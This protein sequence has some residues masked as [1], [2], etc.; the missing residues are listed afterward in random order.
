MPDRAFLAGLLNDL[1]TGAC[2]VLERGY[3]DLERLHG[4]PEA[5]RQRADHLAGRTIYRD[6][7]YA[8][9]G[10]KI[11]L[12]GR[13]FHDNAAARDRDAERDLDAL[14]ADDS[15]TVRLTYG[16]VFDRGCATI[17]KV[18]ALLARRG[19]PG[20]FVRCPDCP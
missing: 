1:D 8:H 6:A 4:L 7:P 9:F 17:A 16:Q 12:D 13:A 5:S 15:T 20:P 2:S 19:W 3:R 10:V 11:E 14:V 18:A